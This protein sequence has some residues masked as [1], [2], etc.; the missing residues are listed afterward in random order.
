MNYKLAGIKRQVDYSPNHIENDSLILL[1]TSEELRNLG[2]E[3]VIY[4][5]EAII[6]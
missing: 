5:E 3:V 6:R 1:K 2:A 4:N